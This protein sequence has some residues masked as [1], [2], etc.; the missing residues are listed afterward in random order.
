MSA[1]SSTSAPIFHQPELAI[2]KLHKQGRYMFWYLNT[3]NKIWI[4][5]LKDSK[6]IYYENFELWKS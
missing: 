1:A 4:L 5:E 6:N 2:H 3:P